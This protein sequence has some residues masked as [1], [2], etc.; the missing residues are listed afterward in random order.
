MCVCVCV[1]VCV[2]MCMCVCVCVCMCVCASIRFLLVA[3]PLMFVPLTPVRLWDALER[4]ADASFRSLFNS[5]ETV[6]SRLYAPLGAGL[7]V[8][9]VARPLATLLEQT[10]LY[11]HTSVAARSLPALALA[12]DL[13]H[14]DSLTTAIR[15]GL[16][17]SADALLAADKDFGVSDADGLQL[18][19]TAPSFAAAMTAPRMHSSPS[20]PASGTVGRSSIPAPLVLEPRSPPVDF[21]QRNVAAVR[22]V[23]Q[24]NAARPRSPRFTQ[25]AGDAVVMYSSQT[26]N[27]THALRET[28]E[29][30]LADEPGPARSFNPQFLLST[31]FEPLSTKVCVCVCVC[32]CVYACAGVCVCACVCVYVCLS[33][34]IH[35]KIPFTQ[36]FQPALL[37]RTAN[38]GH[39]RACQARRL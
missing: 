15:A 38:G 20:L 27:S 5:H 17:P 37:T 30:T 13:Q 22:K 3:P 28:L 34:C 11:L 7:R 23:S 35:V 4:P 26:L 19:A 12:Q 18:T 6:T 14:C 33:V 39:D 31:A 2:C 24:A 36:P 10:D 21:M 1:C 16:F 25:P 9:A 29:T 32:V 8:I